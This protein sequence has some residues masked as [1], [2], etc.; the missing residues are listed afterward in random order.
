MT[1]GWSHSPGIIIGRAWL[2]GW[3]A[4]LWERRLR[5]GKGDRDGGV[6]G[7]GRWVELLGVSGMAVP[8]VSVGS[9][10]VTSGPLVCAL[11]GRV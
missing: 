6:V 4:L 8:P 11:V 10:H 5:V 1:P 2:R 9:R 3:V 7:E